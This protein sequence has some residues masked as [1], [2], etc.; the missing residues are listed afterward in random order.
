VALADTIIVGGALANAFLKYHG[1]E[2][3]KSVYE[4]GLTSTIERIYIA[5][6][7]RTTDVDTFLVLPTDVAVAESIHDPSR[8][9]VVGIDE[10]APTE[11]ILDV[12]PETIKNIETVLK[13]ARTVVWNGTLGMAE[14]EE[15][16]YGSA[17]VAL[18][19]AQNK[20]VHSVVGGG[21]TA[22]FVLK[23]DAGHGKSFSH[24]STGGGASLELMAGEPMPGINALLDV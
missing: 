18:A 3:G 6:S 23:W 15:F 8:R 1:Y 24:I 19:L 2:I 12:G 21:D 4:S 13:S 10:V 9:A 5:A 16:S 7:T 17:R 14:H 22:D 11:Y 20:A